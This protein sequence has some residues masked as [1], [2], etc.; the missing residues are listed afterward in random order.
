MKDKLT[1]TLIGT[2]GTIDEVREVLD[3]NGWKVKVNTWTNPDLP[4]CFREVRITNEGF[5]VL[6]EWGEERNCL[7][8]IQDLI[9]R[10]TAEHLRLQRGDPL[11]IEGQKDLARAELLWQVIK[12]LRLL[13][14]ER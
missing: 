4:G 8:V 14:E 12:D 2:F 6:E 11:R 1:K 7:P 3:R 5:E 10:Y 9:A 13:V